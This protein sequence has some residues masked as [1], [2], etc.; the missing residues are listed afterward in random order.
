MV[1]RCGLRL[2]GVVMLGALAWGCK[3]ST[4]QAKAVDT[5]QSPSSAP[6]AQAEYV[7]TDKCAPCHQE[8][9]ER[10]RG[11]NHDLAMQK[12]TPE[13]VLGDFDG[14]ELRHDGQT[15]RF[16]R[17]GDA[18]AVEALDADGKRRRFPVL[19]TFGVEPLQQY[20]VEVEPGRL[21]AFPFAW[22]TRAK[23]HGGQRWFHL[24]PDEHIPPGDALHWTGPSYNWNYACAD[25]HSTAV[26]KNYDRSHRRY[27]TEY[28]EINVGCE[29][30]HGPGSRHVELAEADSGS[31]PQDGGFDRRLPTLAQRPW[32]FVEGKSIAVLTGAQPSD[33]PETCA[34][35]HS[36]RA[37][38]GDGPGYDD[39]YHLALLD[40]LLYFDDGQIKDE[41]YVYGSFL[42][43]KMYAAGVVC[44]DCHDVHAADLRAQGNALCTRCH[45]AD[46]YDGPQ[47]HFH[48]PGGPG[49]LCTDCHMPQRTYMVIDERADHRFG[50]PRPGLADK[51]G[52]PDACT[53]CHTG[54][55]ARWAE[56]EIGK[57]F[58]TRAAH[59]FAETLNAARRQEPGAE[60]ALIDLLAAGTAP[61]IVRAT[62]LMELRNLASPALP[63]MLMRASHDSSPLVRRTVAVAARELSPSER[64]EIVRP[65]LRDRARTV[66]IEA[67]ATLLGADARGWTESDRAVLE[68]ATGEYLEARAYNAD[69]GEGLVDLAYVATLAGDF[70]HAEADLREALEIDPT[71]TAAYVN[72]ADLYRSQQRDTEA[73]ALL[74]RGLELAGDRASLEFALGL[75]LV[76][77]GRYSEALTHLRRAH[78]MRPEVI[79]FGYIYAVAQYDQG[80]HQAAL[81]TLE[82][83]QRR[84]PAN[85]EVLRL[86]VA[87]NRQMGRS[88]AAAGYAGLLK[89]LGQDP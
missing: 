39:R 19:Y 15:V 23:E 47:H 63:A 86:L 8:E 38:L 25:C 36:R 57:H 54:K 55:S 41:V 31:L 10:W 29:A 40:E 37:D 2:A 45:R 35:C 42:Q 48:E 3:K 87:Y 58:E 64:T 46:V 34:P 49:S 32:I 79:R 59:P 26:E 80:H 68:K 53:G 83:M 33:E 88:E 56:R 52:A 44:S 73:E 18:F 71:F 65:L 78:V 67:V 4:E 76:R 1:M 84:Y 20:L 82:Q 51:I 27:R 13:S 7:G 70:P 75:T 50:I 17:E 62:A 61:A 5:S 89:N 21:Q 9:Y 14:V 28:F 6:A 85:R 74:T 66:R 22:D 81:K 60:R 77:L 69:R 11:S 12:A 72:L 43:S 24:Q 30:C 16:L